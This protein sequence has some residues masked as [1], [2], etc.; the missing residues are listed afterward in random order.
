MSQFEDTVTRL[1]RLVSLAVTKAHKDEFERL[2]DLLS[3]AS[4]HGQDSAKL[5]CRIFPAARN[6]RFYG[7]VEELDNI[8]QIL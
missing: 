8:K 2:Q 5:P 3:L 7:R 1:S 4:E 6:P